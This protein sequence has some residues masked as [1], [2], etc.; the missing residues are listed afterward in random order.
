MMFCDMDVNAT[1]LV[2]GSMSYEY[3][4]IQNSGRFRYRVTVK[5]YRDCQNSNVAFDPEVEVGFYNNNSNRTL[6]ITRRFT[7][8]RETAVDPPSGGSN[9]SFRPNVCLREAIY[10]G[11]VDLE[12][13]TLGYHLVFQRCCR[14]TQNNILD[15]LGQTYYAFIPPTA[16]RNNS[17]SFT[18]VPSPYICLNDTVSLVNTAFDLD[19]DSLVYELSTPWSGGTN[20]E[21][22]PTLPNSW[23]GIPNNFVDVI[24][25]PGH[26]VG[27]PFGNGGIAQ[28]DINNG[29]T[30]IK[31]RT[32]G[33][34]SIAVDVKEYRNGVLLGMIR[35]DIQIIVLAC[36]PNVP[37]RATTPGNVVNYEVMEGTQL[38]FDVTSFDADNHAIQ[39]TASGLPLT[40][41][42]G[43]GNLATFNNATGVRTVTSTFCWTPSCGRARTAPYVVS[44]ESVDNGCP[45]KRHVLGVNITVKPFEGA[46]DFSGPTSVCASQ[47]YQYTTTNRVGSVFE[48]EVDNGAIMSGQGTFQITVRWGSAG[49]GK[50]R[51]R[52]ISPGGC[53][54]E[55]VEKNFTVA[56][57][58]SRPL[59]NGADSVCEF[60]VAELYEVNLPLAHS[61]RWGIVGGI[62]TSGQNTAS[63]R[64]DWGAQGIGRIWAVVTNAQGCRS[65]TANLS[66]LIVMPGNTSI[67]GPQSVCP[68]NQQI[69]YG[70]TNPQVGS[71]YQWTITGGVQSS[72][73]NG[74]QITV[75]WGN[76]GNGSV[77]VSETNALG[78]TSDPI[79]IPIAIEHNLTGEV[80]FGE[81][82][83]CENNGIYTYQVSNSRGSTYIWSISG[84]I[85]STNDSTFLTQVQWGAAGNA[86]IGV[87]QL[88]FDSVNNIACR[89][90]LNELPVFIAPV[91][92]LQ[93]ILGRDSICQNPALSEPYQI[94]GFNN[95]TFN[96]T[97]NGNG[98]I[99]QGNSQISIP[100]AISGTFILT[101]Q[102][103]STF[104]CQGPVNNKTVVIHPMPNTN[105]IFGNDFVCPPNLQGVSFSVSGFDRS[106]YNWS[107]QGAQIMSG[108]QSNSITI[109]FPNTGTATI[110]VFEVSEFSCPGDTLIKDVLIDDPQI[111]LKRVSVNLED[112]RNMEINWELNNAPQYND[113][114]YIFRRVANLSS[115]P[116]NFNRVG[117]QNFGV[118]EYL[119]RGLNPDQFIYEYQIGGLNLCKDTVYSE[120]HRNVQIQGNK[121]DD[122]YHVAVRW[123]RYL[124][125]TDGVNNYELHRKDG[126]AEL[127]FLNSLGLDTFD[128]H[129]DGMNSFRQCYRVKAYEKNSNIYSWSN[130]ICFD[131]PAVLFVPN[132]F[133]PNGDALNQFFNWSYASI[134]TFEISIYDRWGELLY[135]SDNINQPWDGMYRG[136]PLPDGVY[137]YLIQ[138]SGADNQLRVKRGNITLLR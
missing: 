60:A 52:E 115:M 29:V 92:T 137:V 38:C 100:L 59:I 135:K 123:T 22:I 50:I 36:P 40:G 33:R 27:L 131:F 61:I 16:I 113:R 72:G 85:F 5:M 7:M 134:K 102:E 67:R 132:A 17:A 76:L 129:E 73:S 21:P 71:I 136:K 125:W 53:L 37:P 111:D 62:I 79:T 6:S 109:D 43:F 112:E 2:G 9:C 77:T 91:P 95:S 48:W 4:G 26:N 83:L 54:G 19:G 58:P 3:L 98:L 122:P 51:L 119:D 49:V 89:S 69:S 15:D 78:C 120:I 101:A 110:S 12:A 128:Q 25:K 31:S 130:E 20:N 97:F 64:V 65:D 138:Y 114:F 133:T 106:T 1:H 55:W 103:V 42:N 96:W 126:N 11:L 107:A 70:V 99:G 63:I 90:N 47:E 93:Q 44:F 86:R 75:D 14:N 13:S 84:G 88:A 118:N 57:I 39:L 66:I 32:T 46:D 68:N 104:G 34:Y 81:D 10:Q 121:L 23:P 8:L 28:I 74:P 80:P 56:S 108:N 124:G 24:Y 41:F 82:T 18:E 116:A 127:G 87:I 117:T 35:L 30:T 94:N 105:G 45:P